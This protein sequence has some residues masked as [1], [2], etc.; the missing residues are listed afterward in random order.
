MTR[1]IQTPLIVF[2]PLLTNPSTKVEMQVWPDLRE[3]HGP[4]CNKGV[5]RAEIAAKFP[6]LDFAEC[7]EEWDYPP[8]SFE[9][10]AAREKRDD[11]G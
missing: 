11:R 10:A 1:T 4:I 2:D 9:D 5:A 3:T 8:H 6:Q 7:R